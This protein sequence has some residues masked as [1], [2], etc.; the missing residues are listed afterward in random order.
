[1]LNLHRNHRRPLSG[2]TT[3]KYEM[4]KLKSFFFLLICFVCRF[5]RCISSMAQNET[6]ESIDIFSM[7]ENIKW[8]MRVHTNRIRDFLAETRAKHFFFFFS[9]W[10]CVQCRS[11]FEDCVHF[12]LSTHAV[13]FN[14]SHREARKVR[15]NDTK[16]QKQIFVQW[17]FLS[18]VSLW[19]KKPLHFL[20]TFIRLWIF[21]KKEFLLSL[22]RQN[23]F[24]MSPS[25]N[26]SN[27]KKTFFYF[28]FLI[29]SF[30]HDYHSIFRC[31]CVSFNIS[32]G[33]LSSMSVQLF[34]FGST[35]VFKYCVSSRTRMFQNEKIAGQRK[36]HQQ[37]MNSNGQS[38]SNKSLWC[39]HFVMT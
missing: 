15:E 39:L 26:L 30:V 11:L 23:D 37:S 33:F 27:R 35:Q 29:L 18:L 5:H 21:S 3:K 24:L 22:T 28:A 4:K 2:R 32:N 8:K 19:R 14:C 20:V 16:W 6:T 17:N 10:F 31:S 7:S 34:L 36:S 38:K 13:T 9:F 12:G 1:M 25:D